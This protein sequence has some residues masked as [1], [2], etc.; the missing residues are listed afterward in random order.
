MELTYFDVVALID[1]LREENANLT[2]RIAELEE[3]QR[4]IPVS[5]RLPKDG[6][7]VLAAFTDTILTATYHR[8][9]TG[10]VGLDDWLDIEGRHSG[11]P[12]HWMPLPPN[13]ESPNDTQT[14]TFVYGKDVSRSVK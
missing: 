14:Q 2:A 9:W 11:T 6:E 5:E 4:W 13:P 8:Q 10:L 3:K 1:D 12:T 7:Y